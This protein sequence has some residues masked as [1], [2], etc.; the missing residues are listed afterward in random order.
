MNKILLSALSLLLVAGGVK[1]QTA[2]VKNVAKST[3]RLVAYDALGNVTSTTCGVFTSADGEA[4]GSW[5]AL[6]TAS[7]AEVTDF[8]GKTYPVRSIIGANELY[9]VCRFRVE[10]QKTPA[11]VLTKSVLPK[12]TKVWLVGQEAKSL[13]AYPFEIERE[14]S[15]M[16]NY[17]YYV[18]AYN[19]K[20]GMAGSPFVNENGE[21]V[22][23]LK[24]SATSLET[25][26]VDARYATSLSVDAMAIANPLYTKSGIR[27]QL[28][29]DK[30]QAEIMLM[31]AADQKDSAKYVGYISDYIALF[32]HE[33]EGYSTSALRKVALNDFA[34]ADADMQ[35]AL[36]QA[37][38]KAEAHSE[39]S[40][41]MYN[42][43]IYS[44][45]STYT[46][47]TLDRALEEAE[48]A[49]SLDP[50][51]AYKHRVGQILFSKKEYAK[52]YDVFSALPKSGMNNSEVFF[53]A[54]Q[55]KTQ[56]VAK[57]EEILALLDSAVVH[58][59]RPYTDVS[60]PYI[61]AR[62]QFR[63]GM[64]DYRGA[65]SDYNAYDTI[66]VGRASADFYYT[67]YKCEVNLRQFQ[68]ALNDIAHAA[69]VTNGDAKPL[70]LAELASLQLRVSRLDEAVRTADMCLQMLPEST[71]ALI[72]K[73][74]ALYNSNKKKEAIECLQR[75]KELGDPRGDEYLKKYS[76]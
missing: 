53:E 71:D 30:K 63:D 59:P 50:Q 36:K 18:F 17:A 38:N 73:G 43:L 46:A 49:Y 47:W 4:I 16:S 35:A 42:K 8:N 24:Q 32:P 25:H 65:L 72:I 70:Y 11:A 61:L 51:P 6:S 10:A 56:L 1:A 5:S 66:M 21:V 27:L 39:Y 19:D 44:Y 58:C 23:L 9:D 62:A 40:R 55:C 74:V 7:R 15:F 26:A 28:P 41:V 48:K 60:A 68:L 75:A 67:R 69:Y 45:D 33:V 12:G 2:Q 37:T 31:F 22:G 54:A 14:E 34:G 57:N 3:F 64:K 29:N 13:A 52:A 76:K 20:T